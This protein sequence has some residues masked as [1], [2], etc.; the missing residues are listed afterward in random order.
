[1]SFLRR[2]YTHGD[3]L[4]DGGAQNPTKD[5]RCHPSREGAPAIGFEEC[6]V[7]G[8]LPVSYSGGY[9]ESRP[10][11]FT[12][13]SIMARAMLSLGGSCGSRS[14]VYQPASSISSGSVW[15]SPP[16]HSAVKATMSELGN[17]QGWLPK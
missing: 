4:P 5:R 15:I 9:L 3:G 2:F 11:R 8:S 7:T 10:R 6:A 17:G 16:A 14:T 12:K 1:M 13:S